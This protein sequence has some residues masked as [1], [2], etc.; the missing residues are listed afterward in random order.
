MKLLVITILLAIKI[1]ITLVGSLLAGKIG[2]RMAELHYHYPSAGGYC[3]YYFSYFIVKA[4][5]YD[6]SQD[7]TQYTTI[8]LTIKTASNSDGDVL[9]IL[10]SPSVLSRIRGDCYDGDY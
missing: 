2:N 3:C 7:N 5:C 6:I 1:I 9:T 10:R 8:I 4:S